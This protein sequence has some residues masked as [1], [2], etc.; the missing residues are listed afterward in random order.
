MTETFAIGT[1]IPPHGEYRFGTIGKALPGTELKIGENNEILIKCPCM[2]TGYYKEP[3]MTAT[4]FTEDGFLKT[5]DCGAIDEDGYVRITGRAKEIFKT[6]KGKYVAPVPIES[7]LAQNPLVEQACV[8]GIG[9]A[10]TGGAGSVG[11][12]RGWQPGSGQRAVER[13]ADLGQFKSGISRETGPRHRR[14][15]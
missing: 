10:A 2:M 5:G 7:L 11:Q 15:G 13:Y 8:V 12:P 14:R 3:E 4:A 1:S 6:S 9:D